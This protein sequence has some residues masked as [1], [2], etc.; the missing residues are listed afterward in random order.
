MPSELIH[1]QGLRCYNASILLLQTELNCL[2]AIGF[3]LQC[4]DIKFE[5]LEVDASV[6]L[7]MFED[8]R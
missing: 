7:T 8:N 2:S 4:Y 1:L 3:K 6:A 5:P